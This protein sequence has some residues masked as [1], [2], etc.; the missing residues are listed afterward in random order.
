MISEKIVENKNKIDSIGIT[1]DRLTSRAGLAV[2]RRYILSSGIAIEIEKKFGKLKDNKKGIPIVELFV[3]LMCFF[4]DGT[5]GSVCSL[6]ILAKDEGYQGIME[7]TAKDMLSSHT[8]KRVFKKCSFQRNRCFRRLLQKLFIWRL[9]IEHPSVIMLDMDT[10]VYDN[11]GSHDREGVKP[12]YKKVEGFQ[13]LLFKWN[14][15]VI[16]AIFRSGSKH[17]NHGNSV[18][19][20]LEYIVK[21]IRKGYR[22]DIPIIVR[23]DSGF[24]DQNIFSYC[25]DEL[26]IGYV[27]T[28]KIYAD[29]RKHIEG[30]PR[31][32]FHNFKAKLAGNRYTEWLYTEISDK[33]GT[34]DRS[35]RA[36]YTKAYAV[37]NQ[38]VIDVDHCIYYTNIGTS[39]IITAQLKASGNAHL[40][41]ASSILEIAHQ[42]GCEELLHRHAKDFASERMPFKQ[43]EMNEAW[44]FTMLVSFNMY[45][46]FKHDCADHCIERSCY[47]TTFRRKILDVAG[48]IVTHAKKTVLKITKSVMNQLDFSTIWKKANNPPLLI[49]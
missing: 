23:C 41:N 13:P 32:S 19:K 42:R 24:Y 14:R 26:H 16:D 36:I 27:C 47:P 31:E 2:V 11:D 4:I 34:W 8:L 9:N 40:L 35:R 15:F 44:F 45:E 38:L 22:Y 48:K 37:E 20:G 3:Q 49:C 1:V 21:N 7:K 17:S 39:P 18:N 12:T 33:R 10:V 5:Y 30:L 28:G 6:D 29:I 46:G 25:E 43:F